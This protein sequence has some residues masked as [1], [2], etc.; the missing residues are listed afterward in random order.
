MASVA[1]DPNGKRR[2]IFKGLDGRRRTIRLGTCS[3]K[4]ANDVRRHVEAILSAAAADSAID[5]RTADWLGKVSDDLHAKLVAAGLV[6]A[7]VSSAIPETTLLGTFLES[8]IERRTDLKPASILVIRQVIRCLKEFFGVERSLDAIT[9]A[10]C[11]DFRRWMEVDQ[12]LSPATVGKRLAWSSMIF[13]D[14]VE[15]ELIAKNPF[16]KVK[17]PKATNP[18]RQRYIERETI[19]KVIDACPDAEWRLL[20]AMAR[21]LGLR[22]PTEPFNLTWDC[23]DW[24]QQR[25]RIPSIKTE[26]YGKSHRWAPILPEVRPYLDEVFASAAEGAVFVF[27]K[28]RHRASLKQAKAGFWQDVNLRTRFLK[29]I[30]R[31][32]CDP[33]PK[34]FHNLRASAQTDLASR[35]PLHVVCAWLGNSEAIAAD[36]YLQVTDDHFKDAAQNPARPLP[37]STRIGTNQDSENEKTPCFQEVSSFRMEA[38]GIEPA[39]CDPSTIA[40]T[41]VDG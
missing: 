37:E 29:I 3:E 10:D 41:C 27:D 33:W 22:T 28:L 11:K 39:S 30:H 20:V 17:R 1:N 12:N 31:A 40:S 13:L 36:H 18:E 6:T 32:G 34:L 16:A 21:Y 35:F 26:R 2:V 14:A 7:R 24:E 23:I 38:A 19:Q 25:V 5:Q 15:R 4:I 9:I 8:Y